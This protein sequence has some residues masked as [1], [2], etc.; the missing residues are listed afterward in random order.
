MDEGFVG[1]MKME[2]GDD[3]D[4]D[5]KGQTQGGEEQKT[6]RKEKRKPRSSVGSPVVEGKERERELPLPQQPKEVQV[7]GVRLCKE[8]WGV[9]S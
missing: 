6:P 1:W 2:N 4:G 5:Q 9:V 7:K 3:G 8:C